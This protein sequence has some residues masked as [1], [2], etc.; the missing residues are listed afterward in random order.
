MPAD[1][2]TATTAIF[3]ADDEPNK[4]TKNFISLF[5]RINFL[6][7]SRGG[8]VGDG[9]FVFNFFFGGETSAMVKKYYKSEI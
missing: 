9:D 7:D 2:G 4:L 6:P 5:K 3:C 8:E 1:A